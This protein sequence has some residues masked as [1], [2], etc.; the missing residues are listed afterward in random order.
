V[1]AVDDEGRITSLDAYWDA[2]PVMEA[3]S[4]TA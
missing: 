1:F 2:A 4:S 3:I